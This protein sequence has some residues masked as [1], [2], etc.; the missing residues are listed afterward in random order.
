VHVFQFLAVILL[1]GCEAERPSA[2]EA[3]QPAARAARSPVCLEL[4]PPRDRVLLGEPVTVVASI[5]NCSTAVQEVQDLL[6]PELGFLQVWIQPPSGAELLHRPIAKREARGRPVRSLAPG[7]RLSAFVP[8]YFGADGWTLKQPGTYRVRAEYGA[9]TAKLTSKPIQLTVVPPE[10][11]QD[12]QAA[13]LM[14][15]REAGLFL[16]SGRDEGGKGS[17][18]LAMLDR[19]YGQSRLAPYARVALAIAD[20]RGRFDPKT[21]QFQNV[22]CASAAEQLSRAVPEVRDPL[23]AATG[24]ASLVRCLRELGREQE[25]SPA[26]SRFYRSHPGAKDVATVTQS[27]GA[28][29]E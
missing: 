23:I 14:M 29:K 6:S 13:D 16:A 4:E 18:R 15:T 21:K 12:R 7:E 5:V 26:I 22:G 11:V 17:K 9:E 25:V 27:L 20:S 8:V 28:R 2:R 10:S 19:E 24:T 1:L 3:P